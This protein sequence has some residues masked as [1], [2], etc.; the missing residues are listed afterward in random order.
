MSSLHFFLISYS[1][2]SIYFSP[3]ALAEI[4]SMA[5]TFSIILYD[6]SSVKLICLLGSNECSPSLSN[7]FF[8]CLSFRCLLATATITGIKETI[9]LILASCSSRTRSRGASLPSVPRLSL[10][11]FTV[12]WYCCTSRW[13]S[14]ESNSLMYETCHLS[15]SLMNSSTWV[16]NNL[17]SLNFLTRSSNYL[18]GAGGSPMSLCTRSRSS[19]L[20]F[21]FMILALMAY[22]SFSASWA[23]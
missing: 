12:C 10:S 19:F 1:W 8:Q 15:C 3:L 23:G 17:R 4:S 6:S 14:Y 18:F 5:S 2:S 21:C 11:L 20:V 16:H 13:I 9:Y 7:I 22:K